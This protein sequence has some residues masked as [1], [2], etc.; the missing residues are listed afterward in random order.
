M[1]EEEFEAGSAIVQ[2]GEVSNKLYVVVDGDVIDKDNHTSSL[3]GQKNMLSD[4]QWDKTLRAL[5][6]LEDGTTCFSITRG[7]FKRSVRSAILKRNADIMKSL[8]IKVFKVLTDKE[9]LKICDFVK[10][11][12]YN[13]DTVIINQDDLI[14]NMHIVVQGEI[15]S[16]KKGGKSKILKKG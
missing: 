5:D 16:S 14:D 13:G 15:E 4:H 8:K 10:T 12:F 1:E 2:K 3:F 11:K 9:L 7:N 6:N